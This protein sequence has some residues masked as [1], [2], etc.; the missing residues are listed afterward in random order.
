MVRKAIGGERGRSMLRIPR[1]GRLV[2]TV[3]ASLAE[4]EPR[5]EWEDYSYEEVEVDTLDN[6]MALLGIERVDFLKVD[7]EGAEAMAFRGMRRTLEITKYLMIEIGDK[8]RWLVEEL[9][10]MKFK[11]IDR[12]GINYFFIKAGI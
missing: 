12:K 5:I 9:E 7:I 11:L 2:N 3:E 6:I 1:R 8:N 4:V 10:K